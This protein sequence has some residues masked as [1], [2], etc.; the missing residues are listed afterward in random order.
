[1]LKFDPNFNPE[2]HPYLEWHPEWAQGVRKNKPT[3]NYDVIII[4]SGPNGLAAGAYLAKAGLKVLIL[5]KR[6]E[7]GGGL[8]TEDMVTLPNMLHNTCAIY[9]LMVDNAPV[10]KDFKLEEDYN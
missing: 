5:E 10:Y 7:A 3:Y 6:L 4:G 1:M 9:F 8:C 2:I